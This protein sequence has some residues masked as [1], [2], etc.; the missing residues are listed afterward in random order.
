[1]NRPLPQ[2]DRRVPRAF[3]LIELLVVIAIIALLISILLPSLSRARDSARDI[4]C[5]SGL[6]QIGMGIQLYHDS[7]RDAVFM[8]LHPQGL[9]FL[10]YWKAVETLDEFL[11]GAGNEAFKCAAAR[12]P[13]SVTDPQSRAYL[14]SGARFYDDGDSAGNNIHWTTEYWVNDSPYYPA[15]ANSGVT[16]Y[17]AGVSKRPL[18]LI[19]H[20]EEVVLA[21]DA[22]DE[23][24]PSRRAATGPQPQRPDRDAALG[25]SKNN[26]IFGDLRVVSLPRQVYRNSGIGDKYGSYGRSGTGAIIT[27]HE[28]D[29]PV[30]IRTLLESR[31]WLGWTLAG[32]LLVL[33][34][35][36]GVTSAAAGSD[37]YALDRLTQN[38]VIRDRDTGEEWTVPRGRMEQMLLGPRR[39]A[40]HNVGLPNPKTGKLTGFPKS[41]WEMTV[42]RIRKDRDDA[43]QAYGGRVPGGTY[44]PADL[45]AGAA[46]RR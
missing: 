43:I 7:Q 1:M 33:A 2:R 11:S 39:E 40:G 16:S 10:S 42:E 21:T 37:P 44:I 17:N 45:S 18:R 27:R 15:Y 23:F 36:P 12:G 29:T 24:P 6:R 13:A 46:L 30:N 35:L 31:P 8:D 20:Y 32:A 26:F 9:P 5:K 19:K 38:I 22:L 25:L 28:K 34:V 3:T 14:R 4:R 41:D